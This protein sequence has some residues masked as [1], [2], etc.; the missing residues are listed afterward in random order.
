MTRFNGQHIR[1]GLVSGAL[2]LAVC[3]VL[4]WIVLFTKAPPAVSPDLVVDLIWNV[5]LYAIIGGIVGLL[6]GVLVAFVTRTGDGDVLRHA[7]WALV[8][9]GVLALYWIFAVNRLYP[10]SSREPVALALSAGAVLA[11]G[12][13][14]LILL[15]R[16]GR[17][18]RLVVPSLL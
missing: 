1:R 14:G 9:A 6:A 17:W 16:G 11:A 18:K 7:P 8:M 2:I 3:A 10:G 13:V 12:I 4:E 15:V 5:L